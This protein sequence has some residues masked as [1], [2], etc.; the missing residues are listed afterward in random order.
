MSQ[1][2]K[3]KKIK[4]NGYYISHNFPFSELQKHVVMELQELSILGMESVIREFIR[5]VV[6]FGE[7]PPSG[8]DESM[9]VSVSSPPL[10]T[11]H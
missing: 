3:K 7:D 6:D 9:R 8:E 5:N 10:Q 2:K 1:L 11:T 4:K